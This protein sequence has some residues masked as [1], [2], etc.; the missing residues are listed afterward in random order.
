MRYKVNPNAYT[1]KYFLSDEYGGAINYK[2]NLDGLA[3][4]VDRI[5]KKIKKT[6]KK[7]KF[8][9]AGCG[10]GELLYF[11]AKK[12]YEVYGID[13]SKTAIR[14]CKDLLK[15]KKIK[16]TILMSDVRKVKF[17]DNYFD[18]VISTDVVEHL[19]D[20]KATVEFFNEMHRILKPKGQFYIH[21][22]PNKLHV[23]YFQKFYQRY[24][25]YVLFSILEI[26]YPQK[27]YDITLEVRS[28]HNKI[29]HVNEQ[30]YF[31]FRNNLKNSHFKKY[32][33]E[34]FA[35]PFDFNFIKLPY[36]LVG[37]LFPL[38]KIFPLNIFIGNH[39]YLIAEK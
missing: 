26:I 21:T 34:I 5:Y 30:T 38:N 18:I 15:K 28:E 20:N 11:M 2:N 35:D 4:S 25:N 23:E 9:D 39:F 33:L 16:A 1:E 8:L 7:L 10:K 27:K 3:P 36:Y 22:A 17:P 6:K 32:K 37:Y 14:M 24:I 31:S 19:N 12:G 29:V 13:Y